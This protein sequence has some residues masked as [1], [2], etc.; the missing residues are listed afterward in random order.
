M[1]NYRIEGEETPFYDEDYGTG[2]GSSNIDWDK[3][4]FEKLQSNYS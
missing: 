4:I 3:R 1:D 2:I